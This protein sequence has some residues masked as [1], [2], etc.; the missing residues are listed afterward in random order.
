MADRLE[1]RRRGRLLEPP[2]AG[3]WAA[4]HAALPAVAA[5]GEQG[6]DL[7]FSPRDANNRAHVARVRVSTDGNCPTVGDTAQLVLGPGRLGAFDESGVTVSCL[8]EADD[9]LFLYYTGWTLGVTVPFYFYAGLAVS[10]D[11]GATFD[12]VSAAPLL[13]RDT[14]DP[15]LTAS[16]FVLV[17][18][19]TWRMWYVSCVG[20]DQA[21]NG[22][23][24]R[25]LVKYAESDDGIRW[26]RDGHVALPLLLPDEYAISRPWVVR[27]PDRY[28][29]WFSSRGEAYRLG[30]AESDDGL[31][32]E[33]DGAGAD[34]LPAGSGW[35]SEMIA[36]PC[37]FD[38]G[39]ERW[40][41]YNG[42][43]YGRSGIGFATAMWPCAPETSDP[44]P[45]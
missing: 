1:W 6:F 16:P 18:N 41:L 7:Y 2:T 30:Y 32:W 29:M 8:V 14:E 5:Q 40:L 17:E 28:R 34:L 11:G 23:R 42:N 39:G 13:E 21:A 12:R 31:R 9:A 26:R 43:G 25:Y 35:D 22:P 3:G 37:V 36:Y 15:Y 38:R 10:R 27:D 24:H 33:R 19:G 4:T 45:Q 20:W 44:L